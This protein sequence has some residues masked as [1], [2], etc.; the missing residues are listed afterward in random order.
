MNELAP[1]SEWV[2]WF[3]GGPWGRGSSSH[4]GKGGL[5]GMELP[6]SLSG[7]THGPRGPFC[8]AR[9][10]G[11]PPGS[12]V[13]SG[14]ILGHARRRTPAPALG[15]SWQDPLWRLFLLDEASL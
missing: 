12:C 13:F 6:S 11:F 14:S 2:S 1:W 10:S 3:W 7:E 8:H 9:C 5:E 15:F 4:S